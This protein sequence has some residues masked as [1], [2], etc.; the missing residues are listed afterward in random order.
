MDHGPELD[1]PGLHS[2]ALDATRDFVA[3]IGREQWHDP[4]PCEQWDVR[5]LVNHLVAENLWV[6]PLVE[7]RSIHEVGDAFDGDVLGD[8]PLAAYERS[9]READAAFHEPGTMER[10]VGVSYGP[11]P[12]SV[13][14]GHRLVDLV[15]HGWDI[16]RA[17]GQSTELDP[18]LVEA[19]YADVEPQADLLEASGYFGTRVEVAPDA[20]LQTKLLALLGRRA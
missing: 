4:T 2:R 20:D 18:D 7:G 11:V 17:T 3:H 12:G 5:Q 16:A 19:C 1:L 8:D 6:K 15:V 13:F 14:V 10:P 9:G